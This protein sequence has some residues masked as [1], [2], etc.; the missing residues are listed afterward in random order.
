MQNEIQLTHLP[1]I[2]SHDSLPQYRHTGNDT[3][4][5]AKN[6][7]SCCNVG[8]KLTELVLGDWILTNKKFEVTTKY[9]EK[10]EHIFKCDCLH[11][12]QFH[13]PSPTIGWL[14]EI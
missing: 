5:V 7:P 12:K 2:S 4:H 8:I 13:I 14:H 11:T 1:L 3:R 6:C 10:I 9:T